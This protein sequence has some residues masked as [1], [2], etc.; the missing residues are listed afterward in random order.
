MWIFSSYEGIYVL[1]VF[2]L[3]IY[4]FK[5]LYLFYF[6][7]F[8]NKFINNLSA[9]LT[10]KLFATYLFKSYEFHTQKNS[11]IL[12]RNL[13]TEIKLICSSFINPIFTIIIEVFIIF[14][15]LIFL[16]NYQIT[17]SIIMGI[18]FIVLILTYFLAVKKV[19]YD[20]AIKGSI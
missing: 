15:I 20:G 14:G 18:I 3:I 7:Y 11:S 12:V 2:F 16:F 10:T 4:L 8:Q 1:I 6:Y 13:V 19:F 17:I 9:K 5:F